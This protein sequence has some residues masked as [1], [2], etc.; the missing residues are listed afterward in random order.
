M[1]RRNDRHFSGITYGADW[2]R[3][4]RKLKRNDGKD[5]GDA[6]TCGS[7]QVQSLSDLLQQPFIVLH[8][9]PDCRQNGAEM[10]G[11]L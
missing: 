11:R 10:G 3:R 9:G 1:I 2:H 6:H 5:D 7:P 4:K 8:L